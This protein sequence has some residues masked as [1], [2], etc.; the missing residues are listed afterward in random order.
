MIERVR[1][2]GCIGTV[3]KCK[4]DDGSVG[5]NGTEKRRREQEQMREVGK[6]E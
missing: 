4:V 5:R 2:D 1:L 6:S 3:Q